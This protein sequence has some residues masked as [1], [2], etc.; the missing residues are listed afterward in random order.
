MDLRRYCVRVEFFELSVNTLFRALT[1]HCGEV[2]RLAIPYPLTVFG[3][4]L[5]FAVRGGGL[6]GLVIREA[7]GVVDSA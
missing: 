1:C 5:D 7:C 2:F 6:G 3:N 4:L